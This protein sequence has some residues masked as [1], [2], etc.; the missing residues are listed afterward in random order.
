MEV[1]IPEPHVTSLAFGGPELDILNVTTGDDVQNEAEGAVYLIIYM[2]L[3]DYVLEVILRVEF[4]CYD[5][6]PNFI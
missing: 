4:N 5:R 6:T 1:E 2:K 3:A